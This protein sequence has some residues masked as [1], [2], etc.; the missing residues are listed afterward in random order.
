[1]ARLDHR[2]P[3]PRARAAVRRV[4]RAGRGL[5]WPGLASPAALL[6]AGRVEVLGR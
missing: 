6:R 3:L 4:L 2:P 1:M 5:A